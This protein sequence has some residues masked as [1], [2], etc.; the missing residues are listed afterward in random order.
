VGSTVIGD[1]FQH[2]DLNSLEGYRDWVVYFGAFNHTISD[3]DNLISV[4]P[5]NSTDHS[6]II[7]GNGSAPPVTSVGDCHFWS[8][9]P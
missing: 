7:I 1:L 9:L 5:S 4:H 3:V 2:H 6:S 8:V